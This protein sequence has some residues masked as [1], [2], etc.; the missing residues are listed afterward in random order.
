MGERGNERVAYRGGV[1]AFREGYQVQLA[2]A[3]VDQRGDRR[4]SSNQKVPRPAQ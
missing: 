4:P 3:A 1:V 2:A